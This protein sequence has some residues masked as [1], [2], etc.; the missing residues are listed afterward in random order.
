[1]FSSAHSVYSLSM[2][3]HKNGA[4]VS[5]LLL[6]R[7]YPIFDT[8]CARVTYF[9]G[10]IFR[11]G[12]MNFRNFFDRDVACALPFLTRHHT[13]ISSGFTLV[14][15]A[16]KI[17]AVSFFPMSL[18]IVETELGGMAPTSILMEIIW[19]YTVSTFFMFGRMR[20][21]A[22]GMSFFRMQYLG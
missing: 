1:M 21:V 17:S 8:G 3:I 19:T 22:D 2:S 4:F 14:D 6:R 11:Y 9:H 15:G 5:G 7:R 20:I 13:S 10:R 18:D 16:K 12:M